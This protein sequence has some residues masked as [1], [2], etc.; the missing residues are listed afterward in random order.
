MFNDFNFKIDQKAQ[1]KR[2]KLLFKLKNDKRIQNFMDSYHCD[3]SFV[4]DYALRFDKWL[5]DLDRINSYSDQELRDNPKLGSYID[6]SY[7]DG[8]LIEE[9]TYVD[10]S[11]KANDDLKYR[12]NYVIFPL[13]ESL[14]DAEFSKLNLDGITKLYHAALEDAVK[15]IKSDDL[16]LYFYG[17]LGVGKSFLSA[18]ITN[19]FAKE[20]KSVAFVSPSD[21][22]NH[23]RSNFGS[24]EHDPTLDRL[25]RVDVL[26]IDDLGAEPISTWGRDDVL[27]PLLNARMENYR[28]TIF[29]SNYPPEMLV[30]VYAVDNRGIK[31]GIR[32]QR[33]VDR[34]LS[35]AKPLE[36]SGVNRRRL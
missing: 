36:I 4:E 16:G 18:C 24:F 17:N 3:F 11:Q 13:H 14:K 6:L 34:V 7:E 8:L 28:K 29:T 22:F 12:E 1:E 32:S 15:F 19:Q 9:F 26:V 10:I 33:F 5:S 23:I 30:D 35:I 20:G 27:L 25:K 2:E 21:L 31:D